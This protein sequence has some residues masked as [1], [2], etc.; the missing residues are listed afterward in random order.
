MGRDTA[1]WCCVPLSSDAEA[2]VVM[3]WV[4]CLWV[5]AGKRSKSKDKKKSKKSRKD[6]KDSK[7]KK[8]RRGAAAGTACIRIRTQT[9]AERRGL[10]LQHVPQLFS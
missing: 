6:G 10:R 4:A 8:V 5:R 3:T 9:S 1:G 7:D 2:E